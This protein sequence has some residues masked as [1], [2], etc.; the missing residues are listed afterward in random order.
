[1]FALTQYYDTFSYILVWNVF[2][3]IIYHKGWQMF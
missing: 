1:M 2:W 3:N